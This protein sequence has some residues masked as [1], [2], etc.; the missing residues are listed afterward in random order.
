VQLPCC[1]VPYSFS[2]AFFN[3]VDTCK[4]TKEEGGTAC[5]VVPYHYDSMVRQSKSA[6]GSGNVAR[7]RRLAQEA[8]TLSTSLPLSAGS[9]VFVRCDEERLDVMKVGMRIKPLRFSVVARSILP[10]HNC[11]AVPH[12]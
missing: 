6:E 11:R 4:F 3:P 2:V 9:S 8:T 12:K 5:F 7:T 1:F 10:M